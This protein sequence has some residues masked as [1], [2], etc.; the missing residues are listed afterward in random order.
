MLV[1]FLGLND[2]TEI[3]IIGPDNQSVSGIFIRPALITYFIQSHYFSHYLN[4]ELIS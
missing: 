1:I 4:F 3:L 2:E